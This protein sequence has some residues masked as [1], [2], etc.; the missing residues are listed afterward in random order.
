MDQI[1]RVEKLVEP[2]LEA[3]GYD[4]VRVRLSGGQDLC[5]QIMAERV[6]CAEM[7]VEDC[8]VLSRNL[9]SLLDAEDLFTEAY[10]LEVSSPGIDRPLIKLEDYGRFTGFDAR[11]ES[12]VPV[13]DRKKFSG[14]LHGT[15]GD[16]I[17][18]D[19][20]GEIY[21]VPFADILRA[22]LVLTDELIAASQNAHK[23][24]SA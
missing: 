23:N 22:K 4:L 7:T 8:A 1:T 17:L 12:K 19:V 10:T 13:L 5:L 21:E 11:V 18:I 3:L 9:S 15:D 14:V 16:D 24:Q 2:A 20:D 6:D